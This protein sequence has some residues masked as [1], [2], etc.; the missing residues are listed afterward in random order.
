[1]ERFINHIFIFLILIIGC[2]T[3]DKPEIEIKPKVSF[4]SI[5]IY[6]TSKD[7]GLSILYIA[8]G[9][10]IILKPIGRSCLLFEIMPPPPPGVEVAN[11][12]KIVV[13]RLIL[14]ES[15][16]DKIEDLIKRFNDD[17]F[18]DLFN[19]LQ[20]E[21]GIGFKFI[22]SFSDRKFKEFSLI[23]QVS[24]NQKELIDYLHTLI[25]Q[26]S[27]KNKSIIDKFLKE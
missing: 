19:L 14:S 3:K 15:D 6:R 11:H 13:E 24:N 2:K 4:V 12:E 10:E 23:N 20:T 18:T 5:E 27:A 21:N 22:I 1:M 25:T 9:S 16:V 17:D 8:E 26:K 7:C